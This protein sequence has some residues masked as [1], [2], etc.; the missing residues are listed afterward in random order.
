MISW[1]EESIAIF[2]GQTEDAAEVEGE[3]KQ[4]EER[5]E[6][7][8]NWINKAVVR[9]EVKKRIWK[10]GQSRWWDREC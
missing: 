3:M 7:I 4:D 1:S 9:K 6:K 10:I 8:K 5:W 2:K